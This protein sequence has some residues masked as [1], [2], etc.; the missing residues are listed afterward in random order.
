VGR[1]D[2]KGHE[3][4][5]KGN[6][7]IFEYGP[8]LDVKVLTGVLALIAVIGASVD[9]GGRVKRRKR[10]AV[11]PEQFKVLDA[12]L[13][14]GEGLYQVEYAFEVHNFVCYGVNIYSLIDNSKFIWCKFVYH[15]LNLL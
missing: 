1:E 2:I 5:L 10:V 15:C 9:L 7:S 14:G 4:L 3:P 12:I 11:P 13:F 6:F 8:D